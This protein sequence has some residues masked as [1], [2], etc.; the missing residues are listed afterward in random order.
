MRPGIADRPHAEAAD[1]VLE[2][3][4]EPRHRPGGDA[5]E[6]DDQDDEPDQ[7]AEDGRHPWARASE[8]VPPVG[9]VPA[10][11]CSSAN[12]SSSMRTKSCRS[13]SCS[14]SALM[15]Q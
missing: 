15:P 5:I 14:Q 4:R 7:S 9:A 1:G 13:G 6:A 11:R 2:R 12:A 8:R 10:A 3:E